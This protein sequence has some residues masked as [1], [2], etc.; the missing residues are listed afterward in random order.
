MPHIFSWDGRGDYPALAA[1]TAIATAT[2]ISRFIFPK[3]ND[4]IFRHGRAF[5]RDSENNVPFTGTPW[6]LMGMLGAFF[7]YSL[8]VAVCS[9]IFLACGDVSATIVGERWGK[10]KYPA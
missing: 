7:L 9:V 4:F 1:L 5:I 6:Y 10:R 8:P 2:D 3:F